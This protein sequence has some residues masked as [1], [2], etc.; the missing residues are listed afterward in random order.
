MHDTFSFYLIL[1]LIILFLVM[2]ARK[3]K[4]AY[5]IVLVI[6]GLLLGFIPK[7][8]KVSIDPEMIF[9]IFLPPLLYDAAGQASWKNIWKFRRIISSFAFGIVI[10][11][12]CIIAF[13]SNAII[14]GFTLALGFLLGG[15]ISPPDA[16]SATAILKQ[17][18][19]PKDLISIIEGE[20]LMNDAS[21]LTVFKFALAAVASGTFVFHQALT[22]FCMVI[23][24]GIIV[25]IVVALVFYAIHRWLPTTA[26][27]D[28][29][30]SF[31]APYL[32]YLVAEKLHFSGVLAVV[33][34]GLFLSGNSHVIL[35]HNSR[36]RGT[37][38]WT[39]IGFVLNALV[40]ML[41]GMEL[42]AIVKQLDHVS[43]ADAIKYS[44]I[45]SGV[46]ILSRILFTLGA[47]LFTKAISHVMK[48]ANDNPGWRQPLVF[49]WAGM[50]GVVSLASALSIPLLINNGKPFPQRDLILFITFGVI[51]ITLVLQGLTLPWLVRSLDLQE[52]DDALSESEQE[53][54]IRTQIA[55][56]TLGLLH[57]KYKQQVSENRLLQGLQLRLE[58]DSKF[59]DEYKRSVH[60]DD[61]HTDAII[62]DFKHISTDILEQQRKI[63]ITISKKDEFDDD[64]IKKHLAQIDLEEEKLRRKFM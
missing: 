14:P 10:L 19:V 3:L 52:P 25:G 21:S 31:I 28:T 15:I 16:V 55:S 20:S 1:L 24:M 23:V 45:I 40:F 30:L 61:H 35:S 8:P 2:L 41:I 57:D 62:A 58:N 17:V 56:S 47:S 59:L 43:I 9:L 7:L 54:I 53:A 33:S 13:I 37:S 50:R 36:L 44:L 48:T 42:P 60:N 6:G 12:S 49:G 32:M 34:G 26:S 22:S 51:L 29:I 11:T 27:M 63:L 64:V 18:R 46:I 5:P 39:T 38:V 4:I